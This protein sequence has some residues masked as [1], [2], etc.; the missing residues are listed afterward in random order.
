MRLFVCMPRATD[1]AALRVEYA[2]ASACK[3][4][5]RFVER[6]E[7]IAVR[8]VLEPLLVR[9][10][11]IIRRNTLCIYDDLFLCVQVAVGAGVVFTLCILRGAR[12]T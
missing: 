7:C 9:A 11:T 5:S 4:R 8:S 3:P 6:G 1:S 10:R 2:F 12:S